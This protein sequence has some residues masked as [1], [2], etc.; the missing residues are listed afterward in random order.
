VAILR[1]QVD[2]DETSYARWYSVAGFAQR[3]PQFAAIIVIL[4]GLAAI[5]AMLSSSALIGVSFSVG[6]AAALLTLLLTARVTLWACRKFLSGTRLLLPQWFRHGLASLYRPGNQTAAVMAAL[7]VGVMLSMTIYFVQHTVV[8]DLRESAPKDLPNAFFVDI[9]PAEI[10]GVRSL[11]NSQPGIAAPMETIPVVAARMMK[12][13]GNIPTGRRERE[14]GPAPMVNAT[15]PR[16]VN[17]SWSDAPPAGVTV[18]QGAWWKTG[19]QGMVVS[20]GERA[21]RRYGIHVGSVINFSIADK[22]LE[23]RVV[24]IHRYNNL[25][26]G[27]RSEYLFPPA[28]LAGFPTIWYGA[29]HMPPANVPDLQ[30]VMFAKFPT[31]TV[32]NLADALRIVNEVVDNIARVIEFLAAFCIFSAAVLLA[33]TVAGTRFRRIRETVVLKALGATRAR[34]GA[35][36]TVEFLLLGT[37]G[38]AIGLVF[39]HLL[40][41]YLLHRFELPYHVRPAPTSLAIAATAALAALAG[42]A[43]CFRILGQKPL[44]VLR[45]E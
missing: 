27:S 17:L 34:I 9:S 12:I 4:G 38:A 30:R 19:E 42:W 2:A 37:L 43:A 29:V 13:D 22:P 25:R 26:A 15:R 14:D 24:A 39:A 44:A 3:L 10:D 33:S 41:G 23:A 6:L 5:A 35:M 31:V 20:I 7:G 36:L 32:V 28:A 21:S 18:Q 8:S 40:S 1:R 45:E 11:V 16:T